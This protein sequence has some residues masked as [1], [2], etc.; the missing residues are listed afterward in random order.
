MSAVR[1]GRV[2]LSH[3]VKRRDIWLPPLLAAVALVTLWD[4]A[5]RLGD[6]RPYLVPS[7][8]VV[9]A[10]LWSERSVLGTGFWLTS[11]AAI[12]GL[13][14][15]TFLGT[16]IGVVFAQSIAVR[17]AFYPY[18]IFLQTVPIVA[19]APLLVLWLGQGIQSV[20][21]VAFVLSLFPIVTNVTVGMTSIPSS[22]LDL[23]TMYGAN[24]WQRFYKLQ[25][26][27]ALAHLVTG[28]RISSGMAVIGAIVGEFF[29]GYGG[30]GRG[31]GYLIREAVEMNRTDRLFA[32][33]ILST[34]LGV[35]LFVLTGLF[36]D[37]L[38]SRWTMRHL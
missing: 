9:A 17:R 5:V 7:P 2:T 25:F 26:P 37:K 31:L 32:V 18:A 24:R 8:S 11:Q 20:I 36:S 28:V 23:F 16:I 12:C 35:C 33:V 34:L 21:A 3:F 19:I 22:L 6:I 1:G 4:L 14:G 10:T 30:R 38:L 29:V 13:L 15:G 27:F